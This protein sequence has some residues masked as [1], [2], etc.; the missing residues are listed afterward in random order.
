MG[1]GCE[2]DCYCFSRMAA[3]APSDPAPSGRGLS[4]QWGWICN[5]PFPGVS[6]KG[7]GSESATARKEGALR[8]WST[9]NKPSRDCGRNLRPLKTHA[10][11][12]G[13]SRSVSESHLPCA[14][15][16]TPCPL[17]ASVCSPVKRS[18]MTV[19]LGPAGP[20]LL[21]LLRSL[22]SAFTSLSDRRSSSLQCRSPFHAPPASG[23]PA[24][25]LGLLPGNSASRLFCHSCIQHDCYRIQMMAIL[26]RTVRI[27]PPWMPAQARKLACII[28]SKPH[29]NLM[30]K[31]LL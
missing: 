11:L 19:S 18:S 20:G 25:E 14:I 3:P 16:G 17:E 29:S 1:S 23:A 24:R 22:C 6:P 12:M 31:V 7:L 26:T 5:D 28:L 13:P 27:N 30:R 2:S 9:R 21:A 15:R 10:S 4:L 8:G